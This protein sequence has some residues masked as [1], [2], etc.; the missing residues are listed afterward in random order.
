V[1]MASAIAVLLAGGGEF[2]TIR[3]MRH[4]SESALA[5]GKLSIMMPANIEADVMI[6]G[7]PMGAISAMKPAI[8]LRPGT[9]HVQLFDRVSGRQCNRDSV[10]IAAGEYTTIECSF[11]QA[12]EA[13]LSFIVPD[14]SDIFIDGNKIPKL[15][16]FGLLPVMPGVHKITI[17]GQN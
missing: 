15:D 13:E 9:H 8:S 10:G 4:K 5:T 16:R 11:A 3:E 6:D 14:K 12:A 7:T 1:A 2:I 17:V